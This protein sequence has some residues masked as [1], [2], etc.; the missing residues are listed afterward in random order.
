[1]KYTIHYT[2]ALAIIVLL[3]VAIHNCGPAIDIG[4]AVYQ[5]SMKG[6]G[7]EP[8]TS[9]CSET[10]LMLCNADH[11]WEVNVD[12]SDYEPH[13]ECCVI[14]GTPGCFYPYECKEVSK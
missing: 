12:C 5:K 6:K 7:C 4:D 3:A 1:M 14:G 2:A 10:A 11:V 9:E 8:A 13:R